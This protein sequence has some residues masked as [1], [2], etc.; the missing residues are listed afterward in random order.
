LYK[1]SEIFQTKEAFWTAFGRYLS[2]ENNSEDRKINWINYHTGFKD[3]FFRMDAD[4]KKASVSIQLKHNDEILRLLWFEKF[5]EFKNFLVNAVGEEWM[6]EANTLDEYQ[7]TISK[8]Y[9]E[10]QD[11]NVMD[12]GDWPKIISF[13]KPRIIALDAF[14]NEVKDGFEEMR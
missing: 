1:R 14:W 8:I 7:K 6:W 2:L 3:V 10:L 9:I 12:Q 11:V 13:L 4:Q 5:R